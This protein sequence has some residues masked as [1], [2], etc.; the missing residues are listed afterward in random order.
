MPDKK[1]VSSQQSAVSSGRY[2][3]YLDNVSRLLVGALSKTVDIEP[4]LNG[5]FE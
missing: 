4:A 1:T 2:D 5:E 3:T